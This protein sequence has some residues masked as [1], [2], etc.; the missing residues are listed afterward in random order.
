MLQRKS[1]NQHRKRKNQRIDNF[2]ESMKRAAWFKLLFTVEIDPVWRVRLQKKETKFKA[3][4]LTLALFELNKFEAVPYPH[5][6]FIVLDM[7]M[8]EN[9][10]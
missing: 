4:F 8:A 6:I 9:C 7:E 2:V 3:Q 1:N 10:L 5:D